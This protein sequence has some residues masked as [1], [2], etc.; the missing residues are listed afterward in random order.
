M[1]NF[2]DIFEGNAPRKGQTNQPFD[3]E[4]WAE[5]KQ[6]ERQAVYDLADSTAEAV[7]ADGSKFQAY[8]DVQ[9]RFSRFGKMPVLPSNV[10][11]KAFPFWNPARNMSVRTVLSE[12]PT[13]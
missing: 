7:S 3:K 1:S 2:D 13:M 11:R 4:A 5:K 10:S 12:P 8:L 9:P 6:A